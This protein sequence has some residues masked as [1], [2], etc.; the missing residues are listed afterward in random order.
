MHKPL[1]LPGNVRDTVGTMSEDEFIRLFNYLQKL[2]QKNQR[3]HELT[4][5]E[6]QKV[7]S[8]LDSVIK[9]Q[10]IHEQERLFANHQIDRHEGWI[11]QLAVSTKTKL[12]PEP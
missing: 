7:Y 5:G 3:E 4:R 11:K 10:E 9:Q 1:A 12:V 8:Y 6:I 2:E